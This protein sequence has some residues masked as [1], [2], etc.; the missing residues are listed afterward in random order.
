[1]AWRL[2]ID[3]GGVK[4]MQINQKRNKNISQDNFKT[5]F[6]KYFDSALQFNHE[7]WYSLFQLSWDLCFLK[8]YTWCPMIYVCKYVHNCWSS[9]FPDGLD[10]GQMSCEPSSLLLLMCLHGKCTPSHSLQRRDPDISCGSRL[11]VK[12]V[13]W[14]LPVGQGFDGSSAPVRIDAGRSREIE[15]DCEIDLGYLPAATSP[16][17]AA[18]T[19]TPDIPNHL[20][21]PSLTPDDSV[22]QDHNV[23]SPMPTITLLTSEHASSPQPVQNNIS[24]R[25]SLK[26]KKYQSSK[27]STTPCNL[28]GR[29]SSITNPGSTTPQFSEY[30]GTS[31][32]QRPPKEPRQRILASYKGLCG[33]AKAAKG[34]K[35]MAAADT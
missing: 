14:A 7:F 12:L 9:Y 21:H 24:N 34:A 35:T 16:P 25:P 26:S 31:P 15:A 3:F 29:D 20:N 5:C 33:G 11:N 22:D 13:L 19:N 32:C 17:P 30:Y 10:S 27:S 1:M 28:C 18:A 6:G 8:N 2:E 23:P 4:P